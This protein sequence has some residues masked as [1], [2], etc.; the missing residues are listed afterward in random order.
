MGLFSN[1]RR[2]IR[3]LFSTYIIGVNVDYRNC[4]VRVKVSKGG[5]VTHD[6]LHEFKTVQGDVPIEV[7]KFVR[8]LRK[9]NPF[10]YVATISHSIQQGAIGTVKER[11]FIRFGIFARDVKTVGVQKMWSAYIAKEGVAE[12]R[13]KFA[14]SQGIDFLFSPFLVL[15]QALKGRLDSKKRLYIL[16]QRSDLTLAVMNKDRLY[17]GGFFVLESE[18]EEDSRGDGLKESDKSSSTNIT[19]ALEML[20]NELGEIGALEEL[21]DHIILEDFEEH[22]A[23]LP[24]NDEKSSLDDFARILDIEK[25][26]RNSLAEFYKNEIYESDFI[27]EIII[28][29]TYGISSAALAHLKNTLLIDVRSIPL[30]M[31][32]TIIALAEAELSQ[33]KSRESR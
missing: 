33:E 2:A 7:A 10:T 15:H 29:D 31:T 17:F 14:K 5:Q 18:L 6:E 28:L 22:S 19:N 30:E 32:A 11:D 3:E 8:G 24:Q 23:P 1:I 16:Q 26:I 21:D 9:K 13:R 4:Y 27:D 25:F 20:D 12:S